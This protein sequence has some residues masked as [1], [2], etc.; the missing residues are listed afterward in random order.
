MWGYQDAEGGLKYTVLQDLEECL[1]KGR[2]WLENRNYLQVANE[3]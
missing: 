1:G 2:I 3:G